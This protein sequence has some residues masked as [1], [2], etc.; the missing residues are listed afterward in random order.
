MILEFKKK[1][2]KK[3]VLR[4]DD[5]TPAGASDVEKDV[6]KLIQLT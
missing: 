3:I 4:T 5:L 6:E 1:H 2:V